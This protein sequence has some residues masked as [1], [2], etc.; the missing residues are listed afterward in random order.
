MERKKLL[1]RGY[2]QT[3]LITD[4]ISKNAS[5]INGK[6]YIKKIRITK[7]QSSLNLYQRRENIKNAFCVNNN[8]IKGKSI[9]LFDDICTT[10]NTVNEISRVLKLAGAKEVFVLVLAKD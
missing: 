5:I 6:N 4:I 1:K 10:G 8:I 2:N 7:V 9:I 3:E